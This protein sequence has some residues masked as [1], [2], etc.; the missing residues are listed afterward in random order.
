LGGDVYASIGEIICYEFLSG[1]LQKIQ[2]SMAKMTTLADVLADENDN[3]SPQN[4]ST[5]H[6]FRELK[7]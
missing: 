1:E 4:N 6:T 5:N 7:R 2:V 3:E